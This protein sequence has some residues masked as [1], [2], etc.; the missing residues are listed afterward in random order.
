MPAE[1][2]MRAPHSELPTIAADILE[3]IRVLRPRV[4]CITN[5]VAQAYSANML[6][7]AGAV[8]SMTIAPREVAGF[9]A[10]AGALLVNLG[11]FD[12]ER[13]KAALRA[14]AAAGKAKIPWVLDPV[15]ID[16]SKPRAAFA[17]KLAAK[18]PAA[19]RLNGAE[20]AALAGEPASK[21]AL[22]RFARTHGTTVG[23]T[24]ERDFVR[25][26]ARLATVA[27]GHALM[28]RVT[29]MGCAG[30]AL[31]GACLAVESDAWQATAAGL[32]LIGVAGEVAAERARGPGSF[33]SEIVDVL[34][35]LDRATL[36]ARA[37]VS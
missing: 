31:V 34:Y 11:T 18:R 9:V 10:H 30:S 25:D 8:P 22:A 4:H 15:F 36:L 13:Q 12:A 23:L 33:A 19:V 24:G 20:F 28:T 26:A 35:G 6:L 14:V 1:G 32:I 29:A 17:R 21:A 7:A 37:R 16:R 3:R 2:E 5:A 27:N